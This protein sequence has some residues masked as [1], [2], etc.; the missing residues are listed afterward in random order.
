M[1]YSPPVVT[2]PTP[3]ASR[4]HGDNNSVREW[5][6]YSGGGGKKHRERC[7]QVGNSGGWGRGIVVTIKEWT[8]ELTQ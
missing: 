7:L 5:G 2:T 3:P 4:G 6:R 8:S 1:L